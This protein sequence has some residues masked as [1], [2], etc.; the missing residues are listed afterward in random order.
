MGFKNMP[1]RNV[2]Q[3]YTAEQILHHEWIENLAP[4]STA[5]KLQSSLLV[6][7]RNFSS[8]HRFKK[9]ALSVIASRLAEEQIKALKNT[10][11]SLD[12]NGDGLLT[13]NELRDGLTKAS[14]DPNNPE[15]QELFKTI[16]SDGS[17]A[18]DYTE[19]LAS[20]LDKKLYVQESICWA[21]FRVF[22]TN[23]DGKIS[24]EELEKVLND[25][26]VGHIMQKQSI[27]SL[28]REI[29]SNS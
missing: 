12:A 18:I 25:D 19:F 27:D 23:G 4:N 2:A 10:F 28:L 22:D 6:N 3:R 13:M 15:I 16:D 8:I 26:D 1:N 9:M 21:A 11:M 7:I 14:L 17:G 24:R 29:D 20:T 5:V